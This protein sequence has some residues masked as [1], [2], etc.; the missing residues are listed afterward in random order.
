MK[1]HKQDAQPRRADAVGEQNKR[2]I[3][4][5]LRR[6]EGQVRGLHRMVEEERYC[7]DVL[8]QLSAVHESL[9][10]VGQLLLR[11]HLEHC[12]TNA[13][14]SGD[15]ARAARIYEELTALFYKHAR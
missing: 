1:A 5:R 6:I 10:G 14:R 4:L 11:N 13:I 3:L 9:R 2:R 8:E 15:A 12:A 7:P